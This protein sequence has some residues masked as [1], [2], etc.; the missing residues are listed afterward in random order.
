MGLCCCLQEEDI[1]EEIDPSAIVPRS[2]RAAAQRID[3]TSQAA[4]D[5]AGLTKADLEKDD[6]A[7]ET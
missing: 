3:Y 6:D 5:K 7:M 2:R 4:L 1:S